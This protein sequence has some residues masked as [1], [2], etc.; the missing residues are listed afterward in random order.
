MERER[1][2]ER[3]REG[4][5]GEG[6]GEGRRGRRGEEVVCIIIA[7]EGTC[8]H[9]HDIVHIHTESFAFPILSL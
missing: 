8:I 4:K 6:E 1:E 3:E 7:G 2:R 5:G 9:V